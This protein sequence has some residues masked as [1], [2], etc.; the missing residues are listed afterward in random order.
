[1]KLVNFA[2][3]AVAAAAIT[4]VVLAGMLLRSPRGRAQD[5]DD[6]SL[7]IKQGLDIAPVPL[8]LEGKS[9]YQIDLVGLGS[10]W[11][12]AVSDCNFCHTSGGPPN[13]NFLARHNPYFLFQGPKKTNPTTY[14]A[15]GTPFSTALP[16]NVGPGLPYGSYLGPVIVSRNLTPN[17]YG[18]PEGGK[19]L[20]QFMQV[21]RTGVDQDH[22]HPTCK[23]PLPQPSPP[24]CIPPPVDGSRLQVMP[25]PDF[26]DMSD[27]DIE[28][29]YEYLSA[30]P[31]IDNKT[32]TPPAGAPNELRNDCGQD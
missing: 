25:W 27:H 32:S 10:Y 8:N 1:M 21:M 24:F 6:D 26:Q 14:L 13:F 15:G 30:I 4:S 28:A 9:P 12:N 18:L 3:G 19:T 5:E 16:F 22:I 20:S 2:K 31:C 29:I 23:T 7:R 11:V 17:K